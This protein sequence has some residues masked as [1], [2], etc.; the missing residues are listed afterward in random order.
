MRSSQLSSSLSAV[1]PPLTSAFW[2]AN[3]YA[4]DQHPERILQFGSGM[5]LRALC[6]AAVDSANRAGAGAGRIV[7]VQST[8][9]GASRARALNAQDGLFTWSCAAC[10]AAHRSN[11]L[12]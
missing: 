2:P 8:T 1:P 5:L 7:V 11:K 12:A 4:R 3:T 10:P 9:Q 6:V